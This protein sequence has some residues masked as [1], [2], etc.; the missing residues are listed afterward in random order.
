LGKRSVR[1]FIL[2]FGAAT[3]GGQRGLI[4]GISNIPIKMIPPNAPFHAV[5]KTGSTFLVRAHR[6]SGE[7]PQVSH[8]KPKK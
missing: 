6:A 3:H 8:F 1:P 4:P 7:G 5:F 2:R